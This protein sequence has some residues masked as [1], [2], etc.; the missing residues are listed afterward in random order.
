MCGRRL[1]KFWAILAL[2]SSVFSA[3]SASVEFSDAEVEM[4]ENSLMTA[5]TSLNEAQNKITTLENS[6]GLQK[7]Q[8]TL[9]ER[10]LTTAQNLQQEQNK[11]LQELSQKLSEAYSSYKSEKVN[12]ILSIVG[13]TVLGIVAG[14][15]VGYLISQRSN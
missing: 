6:L 1:R 13:M 14:L 8:V 7:E 11:T 10:T 12:Q 15:G 4:L 3:L 2:F 5:Q 9:L